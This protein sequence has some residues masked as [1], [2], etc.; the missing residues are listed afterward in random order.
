MIQFVQG[1]ST[2][3]VVIQLSIPFD[4]EGESTDLAYDLSVLGL[5]TVVLGTARAEFD[6]VIASIQFVLEV[7]EISTSWRVQGRVARTMEVDDRVGVKIEDA[8]S[9]MIESSIQTE[10]GMTG[11]QGGFFRC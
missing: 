7:A 4:V 6:D 5:V 11:G 9:K 1:V 2:Q 3:D 10:S 8:F